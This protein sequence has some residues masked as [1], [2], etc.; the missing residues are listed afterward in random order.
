MNQF[1]A[2]FEDELET[3][4]LEAKD[5]DELTALMARPS[6]RHGKHQPISLTSDFSQRRRHHNS[7]QEKAA[8]RALFWEESP[9]P[10]ANAAAKRP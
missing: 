4:K 9:A 7:D 10:S 1:S 3:I 5:F 8:C 6:I 2:L